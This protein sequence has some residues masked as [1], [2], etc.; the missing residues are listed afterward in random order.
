MSNPLSK[1]FRQPAIHMELP[2]SGRWWRPGSLS[3]PPTNQ[4]PIYPMTARDE[5][6]LRTPD[7]LMNGSS[8]VELLQNCCPSIKDAW[9]CP[10][11]DIDAL[12]IGIRIASFGPTLDIDTQCPHCKADNRHGMDLT[13]R[14]GQIRC[15]NF[16]RDIRFEN[17]VYR[18]KPMNY[19]STTRENTVGFR[20]DK[21]LQALENTELSAEDRQKNITEAISRLTEANLFSISQQTESITLEDGTAVSDPNHI[22]EYYKNISGETVRFILRKLKEIYD[23]VAV[24]DQV[25]ACV[26]CTKEYT[27]PF[28]FDYSNFFGRGF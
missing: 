23:E 21:L 9:S 18:F 24:A 8:V 1:H 13:H 3:I 25:A 11:I 26:E 5:I 28:T 17:L 15:P 2:S 20:E 10:N 14:L 12:L 7:A 6:L 22:N 4:L 27:I 19:F 16:N